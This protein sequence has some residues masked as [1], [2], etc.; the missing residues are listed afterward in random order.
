[1]AETPHTVRSFDQEISHLNQTIARMGH[2]ALDQLSVALRAMEHG[3]VEGALEV[4]E[5]DVHINSEE[6]NINEQVVRLLALRQPVADDLRLI[7]SSLKV[8]SALERVADHAAS[9]ARC[10]KTVRHMERPP[11]LSAV[12]ELGHVVH[13]VLKK[14]LEAFLAQDHQKAI[15]VRANDQNVDNLHSSLFRSA[16][17]NMTEDPH[18]I[19]ASIHLLLTAKNLER[20]G[21]HATNL[22]EITHFIITGKPVAEERPKGDRSSSI[23]L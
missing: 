21:D 9:A 15:S 11:V 6:E 17:A 8:A 1:M 3:D 4:V 14:A 18:S 20:I 22:A 10:V 19:P 7:I 16:L 23:S 5:S 13:D 2:L 12:L